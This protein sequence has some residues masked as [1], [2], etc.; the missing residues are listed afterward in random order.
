MAVDLKGNPFYLTDEEVKWVEDTYESLTTDER[1]GQLFC[2]SIN[3]FDPQGQEN[4]A[5]LGF[6]GYMIRP[7]QM[8]GLKEAIAASQ[9]MCKVPLLISGN[10]EYGGSGVINEGTTLQMPMGCTAT[11]DMEN[12]YRL[13]K[14][15][16]AEATAVGLNWGYAPIIDI[17]MNYRNPITNIR[18]FSSKKEEVL[19]M[20]SGYLRAAKEENMAVSIKHF[21]GDGSD[22]R[23]QHL[24]VS[25]NQ[26]T[27]DEW[28]DSYGWIYKNMIEQGART[29]MVGHIAQPAV[30]KSVNP[31]ISEE[32]AHYP[33]SI[34]KTMITDVL[35]GE[36]GF[37][38]LA[39]TDST[40]MVGYMQKLPRKIAL[41]TSIEAG[42]DMILFNRDQAEDIAFMKEG[43]EKGILSEERLKEAVYR[44]LAL[45]ASLK[46]PEKMANGTIEP[47]ADPATIIGQPLFKEWAAEAAK[48]SPTL[49][50]AKDGILPL[51]PDKKKRI[52]LN[53]IESEVN[54]ESPFALN[55]KERFEKEGFDVTLRKRTLKINVES[56]LSGKM[57]EDTMA[58]MAELNATTESFVSQYDMAVIIVDIPTQSNAT[59]VRINWSVLAGMGQDIPWYAG[60]MPLVVVSFANPYHLLD[61]PMADVY[62]NA[63]NDAPVIIDAVM[64]KL[65]GR[66]EFVGVS[67]VDAFCGH[68]DCRV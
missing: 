34:S 12:G 61:I 9:K 1:L 23:D 44:I 54:D 64:D 62:V 19:A 16:A 15:S 60:E 66:D 20:A 29:V 56:I 53:V 63:Y 48:K 39:V 25:V 21:P 31:A 50:K 58:A 37:N 18:A 8:A 24:L 4:I 41:P 43:Y 7:F 33:A 2:G 59:V 14:I 45:K 10:L 52:Y 3:P 47:E 30:A 38:G 51:S 42:I 6:G 17:D 67:P 49:V 11:G 36:L 40:L 68:S 22:E 65:M 35:R 13:G 26:C 57:D 55:M 27:A 5:K 32:E 46:L 28:R